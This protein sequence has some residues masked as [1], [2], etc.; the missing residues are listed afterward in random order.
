MGAAIIH[1]IIVLWNIA[2]TTAL[3]LSLFS[4]VPTKESGYFVADILAIDHL[5]PG[6][7]GTGFFSADKFGAGHFIAC[8]CA[9]APFGA[10]FLDLIV[11]FSVSLV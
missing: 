1:V 10:G 3:Y 8:L 5:A 2:K 9:V 4:L 11:L 6:C 7:L